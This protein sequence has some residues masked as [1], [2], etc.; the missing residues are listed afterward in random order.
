MIGA[1]GRRLKNPPV[2]SRVPGNRR[3]AEKVQKLLAAAFAVFVFACS[4]P[5]TRSAHTCQGE[6]IQSDHRLRILRAEMKD[7]AGANRTFKLPPVEPSKIVL[8]SDPRIC[9]RAGEAIDSLSRVWNPK[10]PKHPIPTSPIYV[11]E[12]GS[13][14]VV[15]SSHGGDEDDAMF[16]FDSLWRYTGVAVSQ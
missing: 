8:A 12:I 1:S 3:V 2:S 15:S 10:P 4:S 16:F 11:F 5:P 13:S 6:N 7:T 9:L 14:H